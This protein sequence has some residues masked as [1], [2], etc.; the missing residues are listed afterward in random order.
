MA[1][2]LKESDWSFRELMEQHLVD[3][4]KNLGYDARAS[5]KEYGPL[6][7]NNLTERQALEKINAEG[8]TSVVTIVLLNQT[9]ERTFIPSRAQNASVDHHDEYWWAYY[10][11]VT[12]RISNP[13]YYIIDTKYFWESNVYMGNGKELVYSVKTNSFDPVSTNLLAHG[14]GKMIV[15]EMTKNKIF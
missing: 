7:F 5:F 9:Q 6:A 11:S 12:G 15:R 13:G 2:L 10:N 4:L 8:I 3:D 1:L 14:Y